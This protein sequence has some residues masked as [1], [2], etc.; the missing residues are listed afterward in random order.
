MR[1]YLVYVLQ[2]ATK[3]SRSVTK[4]SVGHLFNI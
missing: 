2:G 4:S 3:A 1:M